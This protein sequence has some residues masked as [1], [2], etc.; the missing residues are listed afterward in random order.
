M[1]FKDV[2]TKNVSPQCGENEPHM[3]PLLYGKSPENQP[4]CTF[5]A[6]SFAL[7]SDRMRERK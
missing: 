6:V 3:M 2:S 7:Q 1:P 4:K 5:F